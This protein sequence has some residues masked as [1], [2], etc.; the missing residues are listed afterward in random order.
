M[1]DRAVY[2]DEA[3]VL[4]D[5]ASLIVGREPQR[6]LK[7]VK[8]ELD[9]VGG[10]K[11][12]SRSDSI[13]GRDASPAFRSCLVQAGLRS[14]YDIGSIPD[15]EP[16]ICSVYESLLLSPLEVFLEWYAVCLSLPFFLFCSFFF[17]STV[18]VVVTAPLSLF[19][20]PSYIF[21][22]FFPLYLPFSIYL[23]FLHLPLTPFLFPASLSPPPSPSIPHHRLQAHI[24]CGELDIA[25]KVAVD[26]IRSTVDRYLSSDL[27]CM[28]DLEDVAELVAFHCLV[29]TYRFAEARSLL[30]TD[31]VV[32]QSRRRV[33]LFFSF[34]FF[35]SSPLSPPN[36]L[37][38]DLIL[39]S[40]SL[41]LSLS[42]LSQVYLLK[43]DQIENDFRQREREA[44]EEK[45]RI[46]RDDRT[47]AA[48]KPPSK[49]LVQRHNEVSSSAVL[50]RSEVSHVPRAAEEQ[51]Q[52]QQQH[53]S[54]VDAVSGGSSAAMQ[55]NKPKELTLLQGLWL[56][57][58]Y[59]ASFLA[60]PDNRDSIIQLTFAFL[61][62]LLCRRLLASVSWWKW[63][64]KRLYQ[65]FFLAFNT[66]AAM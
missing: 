9:R 40:S 8:K 33:R 23:Y 24:A 53:V 7:R 59:M 12:V 17:S 62:F 4:S 2:A 32:S 46:V 25:E 65:A 35:P 55:P 1:S 63:L 19:L 10:H 42:L 31:R 49:P 14:L 21:P 43:L 51:K 58:R 20:L 37:T 61:L 3:T 30:E 50:S 44:A 29:P 66:T 16:F 5:I 56:R 52:Q 64:R 6:S 60:R 48:L 45:E 54:A 13:A 38:D 22:S 15:M 28:P 18:E 11:K 27:V 41:S 57:A 34:L 26:Y 36:H 47:A 39:P